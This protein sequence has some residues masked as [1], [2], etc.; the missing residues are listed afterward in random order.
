MR[1]NKTPD[2]DMF[3]MNTCQI[4]SHFEQNKIL[5]HGNIHNLPKKEY[6]F[7]SDMQIEKVER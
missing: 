4:N 1:K 6:V 3:V 2:S 7:N 5:W